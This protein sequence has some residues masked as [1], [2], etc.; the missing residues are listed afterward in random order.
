M[1]QN[2]GL[3]DQWLRIIVGV[4]L[5]SA[6]FIAE[7]AWRWLGLIGIAPLATAFASWCP[8]YSL[9][10]ISSCRQRHNFY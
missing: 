2:I 5:L 9:L 7:S 3:V 4:A 8:L 10:S 1:E 6:V